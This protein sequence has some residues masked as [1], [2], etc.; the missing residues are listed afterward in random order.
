MTFQLEVSILEDRL[1]YEVFDKLP[2][3]LVA[4]S[5][6]GK[7]QD[8]NLKREAALVVQHSYKAILDVMKKVSFDEF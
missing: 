4:A 7:V 8:A 2:I 3:E 6:T 1:K 5:I